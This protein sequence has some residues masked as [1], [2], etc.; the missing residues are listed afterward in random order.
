MTVLSEP[1]PSPREEGM[2]GYL[3]PLVVGA[4]KWQIACKVLGVVFHV[5]LLEVCQ[6][7]LL[8]AFCEMGMTIPSLYAFTT[9]SIPNRIACGESVLEVVECLYH[10]SPM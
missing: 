6:L 1:Q 9:G 3:P 2:M 10:H 7:V 8:I 5:G 4:T